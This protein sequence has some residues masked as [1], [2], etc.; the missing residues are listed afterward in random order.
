[1]SFWK[2]YSNKCDTEIP[3]FDWDIVSYLSTMHMEHVKTCTNQTYDNQ[4]SVMFMTRIFLTQ[5]LYPQEHL[6]HHPQHHQQQNTC[7]NSDL[8]TSCCIIVLQ[9]GII[10][11]WYHCI[12]SYSQD[13]CIIHIQTNSR[14][15][16]WPIMTESLRGC[17]SG[18][19][20][21]YLSQAW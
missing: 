10:I 1:M 2:L 11:F 6:I 9:T 8:P 19:S 12:P 17:E 14:W 15:R 7:R 5:T 20:P 18:T 21:S 4:I 13:R 16:W 3:F